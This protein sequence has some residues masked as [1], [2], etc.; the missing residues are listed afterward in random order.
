[1]NLGLRAARTQLAQERLFTAVDAVAKRFGLT[2]EA[3]AVKAAR[4]GI[5]DPGVAALY[6]LEQ[7]AALLEALASRT[8][9]TETLPSGEERMAAQT[10][11]ELRALIESA[12]PDELDRL[13]TLEA[14]GKARK[15][16]LQAIEARRTDLEAQG[17]E[18]PPGEEGEITG[19]GSGERLP[20]LDPSH[21]PAGST[22][23]NVSTQDGPE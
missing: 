6:Q 15:G 16:V 10:V 14:D 5:K 3:E 11:T 7:T 17:V 19:D 20:D 21:Y 9:P 8:E 1:M 23:L 4:A 12:D 18:I 2:D 13:E 22:P